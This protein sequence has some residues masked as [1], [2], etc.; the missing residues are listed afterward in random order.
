MIRI[1]LLILL[2]LQAQAVTLDMPG[3]AILTAEDVAAP[4]S[5]AMP[6]A[7]W[8]ASGL[9]VL[10][11]TGEVRKQAWRIGASG[12]TTL[13]LL[14]PLEEQLIAAGF[15]IVFGCTDAVCGGFDFRFATP[16]LPAPA[17]Y[18]DLGYFRFVAARRDT[19]GQV[20]LMS[21][22]ASRS[23]AAGFVQVI[24]VGPPS[25]DPV[26]TADAPAVRAAARPLTADAGDLAGALETQ[27]RFVLSDLIFDTG[28]AQLGDADFTSLQ[29]LA[30]YLLANP[31]RTVA[32]VGHTDSVGSLDGN[33]ALSKRR[34]GSVLERLVADYGIPRSQLQAEGMGYLAPAATNL[35]EDGRDANRRVEVI[36]TST[37]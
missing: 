15:D 25:T 36:I 22:L 14:Q 8:S 6:T 17:M 37:E 11:A 31:D 26:A 10:T 21:L 1:L 20:E 3:N 12:L 19:D 30:D 27:G 34:A 24:R 28:S 5:Y 18:V 2:P 23:S 32:L 35:T 4:D 29:T 7:P 33:I 13:Q 9:P 16:V